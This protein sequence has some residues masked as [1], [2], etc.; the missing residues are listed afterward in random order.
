M[1]NTAIICADS[2]ISRLPCQ[3]RMTNHR[4]QRSSSICEI[5]SFHGPAQHSRICTSGGSFK[6]VG[7]SCL[8]LH[9]LGL[10]MTLGKDAATRSDSSA[11]RRAIPRILHWPHRLGVCNEIRGGGNKE[12]E[13]GRGGF[14]KL[15]CLGSVRVLWHLSSSAAKYTLVCSITTWAVKFDLCQP[16]YDRQDLRDPL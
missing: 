14:S 7:H 8:L 10:L 15:Y 2:E 11:T 1:D 13:P 9:G 16:H 3:A 6:T 4:G 5:A 12:T